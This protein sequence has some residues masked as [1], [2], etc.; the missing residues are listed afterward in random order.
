MKGGTR[1][2]RFCA[3]RGA[4][5]DTAHSETPPGKR[6]GSGEGTPRASLHPRGGAPSCPRLQ[7][8]LWVFASPG[9]LWKGVQGTALMEGERCALAKVA[10]TSSPTVGDVGLNSGR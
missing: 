6:T 5:P 8:S 9:Q 2:K 7:G 1:L 4:Q 3:G 10:P